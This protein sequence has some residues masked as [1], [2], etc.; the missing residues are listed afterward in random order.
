MRMPHC[1][2]RRQRGGTQPNTEEGVPSETTN[3]VVQLPVET[4]SRQVEV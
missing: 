1:I 3:V 2:M 4:L